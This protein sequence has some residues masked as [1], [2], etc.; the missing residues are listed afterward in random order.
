MN[1]R[2]H[3]LGCG[4]AARTLA[5]LWVEQGLFEIGQIQ[6]R[7]LASAA[8]AVEFIGQGQAVTAFSDWRSDDWLMLALPDGVLQSQAERLRKHLP[9]PV[10]IA[11][12]LS[13]AESSEVLRGL[14]GHVASAHPACPF[15]HPERVIDQL[16]TAFVL[17]EGD[18]VALDRILPKFSALGLQTIRME[19]VDFS[20]QKK[21]L[22]HAA[23][24]A[25]SN[26][27]NT[28][29]AM[30]LALTDEAGIPQ[31]E[32][33]Q[34]I[35][36]LQKVALSQIETIGPQAALTGPIERAD[37]AAVQAMIHA[38]RNQA[39]EQWPLFSALS[40]ATVDLALNKHP[41]RADRYQKLHALLNEAQPEP[42]AADG[43]V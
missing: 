1:P 34:L 28:L 18:G 33:R 36:S 24:I 31:A 13:G 5:R 39:A 29:D 26:F 19:S 16:K 20:P 43:R 7:S 15:S 40:E 30:A 42:E 10:R 17:G 22:Y 37:H 27:L 9:R 35:V 2:L 12:H 21:R 6:N 32:A 11:F 25:A 41:D 23:T 38:I 4:R 8:A 3:V 14:A